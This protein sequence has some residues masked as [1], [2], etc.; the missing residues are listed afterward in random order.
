MV[1]KAVEDA[2]NNV[3]EPFRSVILF[4]VAVGAPIFLLIRSLEKIEQDEV[5][6]RTCMGKVMLS[7]EDHYISFFST[8]RFTDR[9]RFKN[10]KQTNCSRKELRTY[11]RYDKLLIKRGGV[12]PRYGQAVEYGP[13]LH[14]QVIFVIKWVKVK[15]SGRSIQLGKMLIESEDFHAR[16]MDEAVVEI[17]I[18]SAYRWQVL[19]TDSEVA[20]RTYLNGVVGA[21]IDEKKDSILRGE[22]LASLTPWMQTELKKRARINRRHYGY[23]IR[24]LKLGQANPTH[25]HAIARAIDRADAPKFLTKAVGAVSAPAVLTDW[26]R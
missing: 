3:P 7:Y 10:R 14:M 20:V 16:V 17:V 13:G 23:I 2:L 22:S 24:E 8:K 5:G 1:P 9:K 25:E 18:D 21:L 15:K 26:R 12:M 6:L 11:K 4:V 19:H